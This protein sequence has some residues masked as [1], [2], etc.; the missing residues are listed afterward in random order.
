MW[1][2]SH[3]NEG[4]RAVYLYVQQSSMQWGATQGNIILVSPTTDDDDES[5]RRTKVMI[6]DQITLRFE[7]YGMARRCRVYFDKK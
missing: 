1:A 6:H 5:A 3:D 7:D 2:L 4:R